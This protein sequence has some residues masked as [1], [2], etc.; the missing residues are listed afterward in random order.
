MLEESEQKTKDKLEANDSELEELKSKI[1][2]LQNEVENKESQLKFQH[3][4]ND[5]LREQNETLVHHKLLEEWCSCVIVFDSNA[6]DLCIRMVAEKKE[7]IQNL[8]SQLEE[9]AKQ[10][11]EE[12]HLD[13]PRNI[14]EI[15]K[16]RSK[17]KLLVR[18]S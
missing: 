1:K 3:K 2:T 5:L 18:N 13:R 11:S 8:K 16:D 4:L 9:A 14:N 12:S 7:E 10:K 15:Y 17:L 6:T